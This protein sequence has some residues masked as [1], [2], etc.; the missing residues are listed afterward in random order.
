MAWPSVT[1]FARKAA[2]LSIALG[3]GGCATLSEDG[4]FSSVAAQA[5]VRA[6]PRR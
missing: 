1:P 6:Q 2:V 5:G 3:L 4:G